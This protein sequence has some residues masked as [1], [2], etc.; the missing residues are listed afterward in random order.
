MTKQKIIEL[1]ILVIFAAMVVF[2]FWDKYKQLNPANIIYVNSVHGYSLQI[3][4]S[5]QNKYDVVEQSQ[6]STISF[7]YR[8]SKNEAAKIFSISKTSVESW[9]TISADQLTSPVSRL[10]VEQESQVYYARWLANNP[11][12]GQEAKSY[13][14]LARDVSNI[15]NTFTINYQKN[16]S[17]TSQ[18]VCIQVITS[19]KNLETG[20]IKEFPTPCDVPLGWE[21]VSL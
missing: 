6:D 20:E 15:L 7:M 16:N 5:W 13:L 14:A 1:V 11:Y 17:S 19:A 8:S 12:K 3:P 9:K 10:L 18:E 21:A 4:A 2:I